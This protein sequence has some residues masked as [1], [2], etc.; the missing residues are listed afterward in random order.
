MQGLYFP[1]WERQLGWSASGQRTDTINGRPA[2]TVYYTWQGHEVAY[3][4]VG[5]PP[6]RLPAADS[7]WVNG[8][9]VRTMTLDGRLV[10]TWRRDGHTC[11]LSASGVP[12]A[13]LRLLAATDA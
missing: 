8:T 3:T 7:T 4:I 11:V 9:R 5:A 2:V 1:N 10:V 12:A 13:Q 6:L